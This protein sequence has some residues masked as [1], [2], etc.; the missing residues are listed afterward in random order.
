MNGGVSD[1]NGAGRRR[2]LPYDIGSVSPNSAAPRSGSLRG[3]SITFGVWSVVGLV[4]AIQTLARLRGAGVPLSWERLVLLPLAYWYGWALWTPLIFATARR[5]MPARE[6]W[7]LTVAKHVGLCLAVSLVMMGWFAALMH[8]LGGEDDRTLGAVFLRYLTLGFHYDL[9]TYAAILGVGFA[10]GYHDLFRERATRALQLEHRLVQSQLEV[11]RMQLRPHFFFNTLHAI[12]SLIEDDP[13][14]ARRMIARL[15]GLLR[16]TLD[17]GDRQEI[18]LRDELEILDGYLDIE[19][20]RFQDRLQVERE[21][22]E[23]CLDAPVPSL[24]LQP[25]VENAVRHGIEEREGRC[26]IRVSARRAGDRLRLEV[27]DHGP[28]PPTAEPLEHAEGIGLP[29]VR[30]RLEQMYPGQATLELTAAEG[31]GLQ[32]V[33]TLPFR[34]APSARAVPAE[35]VP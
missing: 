21:V 29:N 17:L 30:T 32:A 2:A 16:Q 13:G 9:L 15:S 8:S 5:W 19:A 10:R 6:R 12:A 23:D 18:S 24:L 22:A 4:V 34:P 14:N 35:V 27:R 31:G 20:C 3:W 28:G 7:A 25:L 33:V 1:A 11:L 26:R